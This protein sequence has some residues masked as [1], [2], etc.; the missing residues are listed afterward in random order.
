MER[1]AEKKALKEAQRID[2]ALAKA[3]KQGSI[4]LNKPRKALGAKQKLV[5]STIGEGSAPV[6]KRAIATNSRG[7]PVLTP[8][9]FL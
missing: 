7:R 1:A 4:S 9:R 3:R 6:A 2:I 5:E 8:A